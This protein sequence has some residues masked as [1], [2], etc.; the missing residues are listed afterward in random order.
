MTTRSHTR[1]LRSSTRPSEKDLRDPATAQNTQQV[2]S[3]TSR[4]KS[5]FTKK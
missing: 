5:A 3:T 4:I 1:Q 2:Q